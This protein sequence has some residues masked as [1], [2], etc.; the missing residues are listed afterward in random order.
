MQERSVTVTGERHVLEEP[1][2]VLATQNPIE[3]EGTYP[4]PEAQLDRFLYKLVVPFPQEKEMLKILN[5]TTTDESPEIRPVLNREKIRE[6]SHFVLQVPVAE[7]VMKFAASLVLGSHPEHPL[8]PES[9]RR[10][11]RYGSSPRGAQA[12]IL[13][14]KLRALR[15]N[16]Y[17]AAIEDIVA[18]AFPCLRH[19]FILNIEGQ[20]EGISSDILIRDLLDQVQHRKPE[21]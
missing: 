7:P 1:F 14:A 13:S 11:V 20:A 10:F 5:R 16:R 19:R 12:L 17:H 4:L 15:E 8:A 18:V 3:M 21:E 6:F 2:Y 9:V